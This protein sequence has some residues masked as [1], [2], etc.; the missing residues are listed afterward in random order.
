MKTIATFLFTVL[1]SSSAFNTQ[2]GSLSDDERTK[3]IDYLKNT[4]SELYEA[5]KGLTSEQLNYKS[6]EENWSIAE[7]V[8]HI[9]ISE[10]LIFGIVES[11]LQATPAKKENPAMT[12]EQIMGFIVDRTNKVKTRPEFEPKKSFGSY[13]ATLKEYKKLRKEHISFI[14]RT[15]ED[16]RGHY[17][18]FP[19]GMTDTYQVVLFMS[20]HSMRHVNQIKE[21]KAQADFPS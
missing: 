19:F 1:I 9:A 6:S 21:I 5:I 18:E 12:D 16:L 11:A 3:A 14:K 10:K 2:N 17:Y 13:Q 20:G 7:C 8:E 4:E 15:K